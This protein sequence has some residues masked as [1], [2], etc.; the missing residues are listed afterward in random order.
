MSFSKLILLFFIALLLLFF[1]IIIPIHPSIHLSFLF[2]FN[3]HN[4]ITLLYTHRESHEMDF[5]IKKKPKKNYKMFVNVHSRKTTRQHSDWLLLRSKI[6]SQI[7]ML[8]TNVCLVRAFYLH[9]VYCTFHIFVIRIF[10][11]F[12]FFLLQIHYDDDEIAGKNLPIDLWLCWFC[13]IGDFNLI[14]INYEERK[15]LCRCGILFEEVLMRDRKK[16]RDPFYLWQVIDCHSTNFVTWHFL[17][18]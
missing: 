4:E 6:Q 12:R 14:D 9:L 10:L 8:Q 13:F 1:H 15:K 11:L 17:S 7:Y 5:R 16:E 18:Q 2:I 3:I